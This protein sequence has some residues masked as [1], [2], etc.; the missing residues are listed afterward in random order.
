MAN[1]GRI[2]IDIIANM[3]RFNSALSAASR[4][5]DRFGQQTQQQT[6]GVTTSTVAMG[7]AYAM[8]AQ[9]ATRAFTVIIDKIKE[10]IIASSKMAIDME[11]SMMRLERVFGGASGQVT[12]FMKEQ[13]RALNLSQVQAARYSS[14]FGNLLKNMGEGQDATAKYS[15]SLLK[16]AAVIKSQESRFTMEEILD[17]LRSGVLGNVQAIDDLGIEAKVGML[18]TTSAFKKIAGDKSWSQLTFQQQQQIRLFGILEQGANLYGN[19]LAKTTSSALAQFNAILQDA[20]LKLGQALLPVIQKAVPILIDFAN[21][22]E[23]IVSKLKVMSDLLFGV[24]DSAAQASTSQVKLGKDIQKAGKSAKKSLAPFDEIV[25]IQDKMSNSAKTTTSVSG[26]FS[27]PSQSG[28]GGIS[29]AISEIKIPDVIAK[30]IEK[31]KESFAGLSSSFKRLKESSKPVLEPLLELLKEF[32]SNRIAGYIETFALAIDG[33]ALAFDGLNKIS[34]IYKSIQEFFN[35]ALAPVRQFVED[36]KLVG[37]DGIREEI[38]LTWAR[39][40]INVVEWWSW[41][42]G[43]LKEEVN[44]IIKIKWDDIREKISLMWKRTYNN[45]VQWWTWIKSWLDNKISDIAENLGWDYIKNKISEMWKGVSDITMGIWEGIKSGVKSGLMFVIDSINKVIRLVNK[46]K[47]STPE[48]NIPATFFTPAVKIPSLT[49]GFGDIPEIP[50]DSFTDTAQQQGGVLSQGQQQGF[51]DG[52][53]PVAEG[54]EV[55]IIL[56]GVVVGRG[57]IPFI[58]QEQQRLGLGEGLVIE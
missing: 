44:N 29:G 55:N 43:L 56:D 52:E 49:F 32:I 1:G 35:N 9:V 15:I 58:A 18:R 34:E 13:A 7:N 4:R 50:T 57:L 39:V 24:S 22:L 10:T 3:N 46:I 54:R 2:D 48:I 53:G 45:V 31:L 30:S 19:T 33:L 27:S 25:A 38:S 20:S 23:F 6:R 37:W 11:S 47:F 16:L 5:I 41:I 28:L 12:D 21:G 26:A 42:K 51:G 17:K 40:Y 36:V 14:T 8:L